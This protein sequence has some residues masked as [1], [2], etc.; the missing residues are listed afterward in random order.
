MIFVGV[1]LVDGSLK[2][3]N[4]V[5]FSKAFY[6]TL[7]SRLFWATNLL[8]YDFIK[9]FGFLFFC[10]LL[11]LAVFLVSL[12]VFFTQKRTINFSELK[13]KTINEVVFLIVLGSIGT[14]CA[15]YG[16]SKVGIFVFAILALLEPCVSLIFSR[17]YYKESLTKLQILGIVISVVASIV[18][19]Q[20]YYKI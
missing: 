6:L 20:N 2:K 18:L 14:L 7:L 17:F 8:F 4:G 16:I 11:E 3:S 10:V 5:R 9:E 19:T 1:L 13:L 15:V 12:T